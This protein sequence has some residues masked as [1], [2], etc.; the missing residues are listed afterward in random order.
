MIKGWKNNPAWVAYYEAKED[1]RA[2]KLSNRL[3]NKRRP[4]D[5]IADI[6]RQKEQRLRARHLTTYELC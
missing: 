2:D 3:Q 1:A 5:V 4:A 6:R